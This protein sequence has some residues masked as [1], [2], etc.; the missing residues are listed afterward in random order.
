MNEKKK[1]KKIIREEHKKMQLEQAENAGQLE[2]MIQG[3]LDQMN[4][5]AELMKEIIY[6]LTTEADDKDMAK[7]LVK[8]HGEYTRI[9]KEVRNSL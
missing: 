7:E 4:Q 2:N 3:A 9:L 8:A 6:Y 5:H 1:I